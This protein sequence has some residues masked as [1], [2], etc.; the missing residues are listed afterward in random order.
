[1]LDLDSFTNI[2]Q[3]KFLLPKTK[4]Q[5]NKRKGIVICALTLHQTE[6]YPLESLTPKPLKLL[7]I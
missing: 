1:M 7:K 6:A 4:N 2:Y 5:P 3:D